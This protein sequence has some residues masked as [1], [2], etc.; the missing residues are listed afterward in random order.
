MVITPAP[1]PTIPSSKS[2]HQC[3]SLPTRSAAATTA[4]TPSTRA[5]APNNKTSASSVISGQTMVSAPK[6][7]A[8]RPRRANAHQFRSS[9][10]AMCPPFCS[11]RLIDEHAPGGAALLP[12]SSCGPTH[13]A[14]RLAHVRRS[15]LIQR[16]RAAQD[17]KA[18]PNSRRRSHPVRTAQRLFVNRSSACSLALPEFSVN[19]VIA[20][21]CAGLSPRRGLAVTRRGKPVGKLLQIACE[22]AQPGDVG[23]VVLD[24]LANLRNQLFGP[25]LFVHRRSVA[26]LLELALDLVRDRVGVVARL[27]LF[28]PPPVFVGVP[29]R[30]SHHA[31][32]LLFREL[33]RAADGDLL[34]LASLLVARGDCQD[35]VG[36]RVERDFDLRQTERRG[37]DAFEPEV[38]ERAVVPREFSLALQHV[39]VYPRLVVRRRR[40][41]FRFARRN[42]RVAL[43]QF[44]HHAAH[45]FDT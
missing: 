43:N 12:S 38:A 5:K 7:M 6:R 23:R 44:G 25:R 20:S 37:T 35:A 19:H 13:R 22:L 21:S 15:R 3:F 33:R 1:M 8:A 41:G 11:I 14:R 32:N 4:K 39:N 36:V 26:Q 45:R 16:L 2:A 27:D 29:L 28:T 42:S 17:R 30:V 24:Q 9:T 34:L 10:S 40:E 31:I 18:A